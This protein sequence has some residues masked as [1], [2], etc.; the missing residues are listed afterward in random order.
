MEGQSIMERGRGDT[1]TP[2]A[3]IV[4]RHGGATTALATPP[5]KGVQRVTPPLFICTAHTHTQLGEDS[6]PDHTGTLKLSF[7]LAAG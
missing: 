2:A 5:S 4:S 1:E 6:S 3:I 7:R